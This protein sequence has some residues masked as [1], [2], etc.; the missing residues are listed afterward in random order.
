MQLLMHQHQEAISCEQFLG[1]HESPCSVP[2][3]LVTDL[4]CTVPYVV[5]VLTR[6]ASRSTITVFATCNTI[7]VCSTCPGHIQF[8]AVAIYS[9]GR[10]LYQ[11]VLPVQN[12][13]C[14]HKVDRS[15]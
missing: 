13:F 5:V 1:Q 9:G 2:M 11:A 12:M 7:M 6:S 15:G 10:L 4:C 14:S 3:L 8:A